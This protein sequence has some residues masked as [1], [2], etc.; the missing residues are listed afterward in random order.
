MMEMDVVQVVKLKVDGPASK[1][2][3][4]IHYQF[5]HPNVVMVKFLE[6]NNVMMVIL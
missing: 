2:F 3:I 1:G 6:M 4:L 5:V